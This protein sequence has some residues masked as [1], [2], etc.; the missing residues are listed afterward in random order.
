MAATT[1]EKTR[2]RRKLDGTEVTMPD[3]YIDDVF[4][5]AE[6]SYTGYARPVIVTAAYVLCIKDMKTRAARL[7]D[8][9]QNDSSE[10]RSQLLK[11][12]DNLLKDYEGELA[13]LVE[14]G[15]SSPAFFGVPNVKPSRLKE[16]PDD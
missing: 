3:A 1:A 7:T 15:S 2:F 16:Y 11:N 12:L 5:E 8:Y 6:E 14:M 4:N 10:K 13:Q 9:D